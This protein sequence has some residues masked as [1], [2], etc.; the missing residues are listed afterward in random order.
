ML[1]DE[2]RSKMNITMFIFVEI[3]DMD[4]GQNTEKDE[5]IKI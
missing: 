3:R 1:L 2:I 4:H 5:K